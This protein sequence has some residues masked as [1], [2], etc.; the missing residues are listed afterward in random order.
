MPA[1]IPDNIGPVLSVVGLTK[2]VSRIIL[3][4]ESI[5]VAFAEI[6][7]AKVVFSKPTTKFSN[8]NVLVALLVCTNNKSLLLISVIWGNCFILI[9]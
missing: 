5:F 8:F 3:L 6:V 1:P 4:T 7:E 9:L 2:K